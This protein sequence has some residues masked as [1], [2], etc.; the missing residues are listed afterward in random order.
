M[1]ARFRPSIRLL[2]LAVIVSL[3]FGAIVI[4]QSVE[5]FQVSA[6]QSVVS[7]N[8]ASFLG[9]LAPATIAAAFG[10]NLATR[11]EAAQSL[12]LP[13]QI[14]GVTVRVIDSANVEHFARLFFVSPGQ[15]NYLIPEQAAPGVAQIIV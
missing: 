2:V 13:T 12:P 6:A 9:P 1:R 7:V 11:L 8:A 15:I 3:S 4:K 5:H 10:N 14:A